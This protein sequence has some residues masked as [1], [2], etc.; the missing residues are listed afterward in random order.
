MATSQPLGGVLEHTVSGAVSF[1]IA[2]YYSWSV[3]LVTICTAPVTAVVLGW[4]AQRTQP[5][6][7][8][9]RDELSTALKH[10]INAIVSIETVKC[11]NGEETEVRKYST[12]IHSAAVWYIR[13]AQTNAFQIAFLQAVV[14][15][16][17]AQG[18]WFGSHL[19]QTGHATTG[20]VITSFWSTLTATQSIQSILPNLI[21]LE[22]GRAAGNALNTMN[23]RN[24][25][26]D[27]IHSSSKLGSL[28]MAAQCVGQ[29]DFNSVSISDN[30][31]YFNTK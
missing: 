18:F 14:M 8:Q 22:K 17:F 21:V 6:I 23:A 4:L 15:T 7:V 25:D 10:G 2:L 5:A 3:T 13:Q 30:P 20:T 19:V 11:S 28:P 12:A 27:G 31:A 9:Q 16:M 1:G 29:V 26:T 24:H